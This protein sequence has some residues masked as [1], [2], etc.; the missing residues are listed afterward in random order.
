M[1]GWQL[2]VRVGLLSQ[3]TFEVLLIDITDY[4]KYY[5]GPCWLFSISFWMFFKKFLVKKT[6]L[7]VAW[8]YLWKFS[9]ASLDLT[10]LSKASLPEKNINS[11]SPNIH[12]QIL[13]TDLH[14]F[15]YRISWENLIKDQSVIPYMIILFTLNIFF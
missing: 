6:S 1:M 14:T 8:G 2:L 12:I 9:F 11:L 15:L 13:Q 7:P 5:L 10:A 4:D 3:M